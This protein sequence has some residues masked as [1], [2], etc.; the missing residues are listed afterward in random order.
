MIDIESSCRACLQAS[1]DLEPLF[2][3]LFEDVPLSKLFICINPN[4]GKIEKNDQLSNLICRECTANAI[5]AYKFQQMCESNDKKIRT[6]IESHFKFDIDNTIKTEE[7]GSGEISQD[8]LS[9]IEKIEEHLQS[10]SNDVMMTELKPLSDEYDS[11]QDISNEDSDED[12]SID[13]EEEIAESSNYNCDSCSKSFSSVRKLER[14]LKNDHQVRK[15]KSVGS[16]DN[17][18][19]S[20]DDETTKIF[21]CDSCPK[22]F[23]K[24]SLLARHIKTHDPNKRP[25]E[26]SKCQKRFPS[27]V[28]LVRH[29]I[30]HSELVER[31]KIN[32]PDP[33]DF[34][35]VVCGRTFKS[36]ESLTSHLKT[37]KNKSPENQE[38]TCKLCHDVFPTFTDITRHSKNHIENATHQCAICNKLFVVGDELIDH[39]LR[40]KGMKPHQCPVCEKSFLK[41]HKLNV[42]MRIHSDDK[43]SEVSP[44]KVSQIIL[45]FDF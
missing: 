30:L 19:S 20:G 1:S 39:F 7:E 12:S 9:L 16:E 32:R 25:H 4:V 2:E 22:K 6:L 14:H 40:H 43:V 31:S 24:P 42:H 10:D 45:N 38:Y 35:C 3:T 15:S 36:A 33:Q 37:H 17:D 8:G 13:S 21:T 26:C 5:N 29:D 28:A 41:L 18:S 23:K 11:E 34:S 27:Q 44:S